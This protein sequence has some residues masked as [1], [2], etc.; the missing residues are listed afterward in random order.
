M[1][2]ISKF[3]YYFFIIRNQKMLSKKNISPIIHLSKIKENKPNITLTIEYS[4]H[5]SKNDKY[6]FENFLLYTNEYNF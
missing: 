5:H 1:K 3:A 4:F 6:N 2:L